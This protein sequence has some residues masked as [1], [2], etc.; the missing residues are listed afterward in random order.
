M[1][2]RTTRVRTRAPFE[3]IALLLQGGGALAAYQG[4]RV[5]AL[6]EADLHPDWVAG[7]S[8]AAINSNHHRQSTRGARRYA[9]SGKRSPPIRCSTGPLQASWNSHLSSTER[10]R[11]TK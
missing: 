7:I 1:R 5:Q 6:A 9:R 8:I 4:G 11:T 3:C 10:V 2:N